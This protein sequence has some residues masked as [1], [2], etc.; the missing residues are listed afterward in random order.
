MT[1]VL[2][3]IGVRARDWE[4]LYDQLTSTRTFNLNVNKTFIRALVIT[5]QMATSMIWIL[6]C[7]NF[8][9]HIHQV[10]GEQNFKINK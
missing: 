6:S 4:D 5:R 9:F 10:V 7:T 8:V 1:R 2:K 3:E